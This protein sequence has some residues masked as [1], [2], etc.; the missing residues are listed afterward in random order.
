MILTIYAAL[1]IILIVVHLA[2]TLRTRIIEKKNRNGERYYDTPFSR[3]VGWWFVFASL[4]IALIANFDV[5]F[6]TS[7]V[8]GKLWPLTFAMVVAHLL[9]HLV[10]P[11]DDSPIPFNTDSTGPR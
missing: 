11:K 4:V 9:V 7:Q 8:I 5:V 6:G 10:I 1:T 3:V 2:L